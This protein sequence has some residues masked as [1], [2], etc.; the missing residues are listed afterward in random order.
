MEIN[1]I[2]RGR[3]RALAIHELEARLVENEILVDF[4]AEALLIGGVGV[5]LV[6]FGWLKGLSEIVEVLCLVLC[7]FWE[8]LK[9]FFEL[10]LLLAFGV[11]QEIV[12]FGEKN[13][14]SV[15]F[16]DAGPRFGDFEGGTKRDRWVEGIINDYQYLEFIELS[17]E[18]NY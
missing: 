13:Q 4:L 16:L 1:F 18:E 12:L 7:E 3:I 9:R 6:V 14:F 11:I 10:V 8:P 5:G 15:A 2:V 17:E